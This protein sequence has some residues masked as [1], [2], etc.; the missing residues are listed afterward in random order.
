MTLN[1]D[2]WWEEDPDD[3]LNPPDEDD[4]EMLD[5]FL[6]RWLGEVKVQ[7]VDGNTVF[8]VGMQKPPES[9]GE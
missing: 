3:L 7:T 4:E 9:S 5:K 8:V 6:Q 2:P 1:Q